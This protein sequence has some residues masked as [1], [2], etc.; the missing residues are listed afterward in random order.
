MGNC[1]GKNGAKKTGEVDTPQDHVDLEGGQ[2]PAVSVLTPKRTPKKKPGVPLPK[3]PVPPSSPGAGFR[4]YVA[5]FDYDARTNEDLTFKKGEYL[6]VSSDN[7]Q[8][9]WW[10]AKSRTSGKQGYIPSN[11]VAEVKTLEAE[12]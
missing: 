9:D 2:E 10:Q 7:T 4:L 1:T 12:E 3:T 6:E 5:I 11:Y 8:F